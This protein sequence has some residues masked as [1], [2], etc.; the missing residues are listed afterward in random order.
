MITIAGLTRFRNK[1]DRPK[2]KKNAVSLSG[3]SLGKVTRR[4]GVS[5][6]GPV[7]ERDERSVR[8]RVEQD[9]RPLNYGKSKPTYRPDQVPAGDLPHV[10]S[11]RSKKFGASRA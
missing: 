3:Q 4:V 2:L 6:P 11:K 1:K 5:A 8:R 10:V 9:R 7:K